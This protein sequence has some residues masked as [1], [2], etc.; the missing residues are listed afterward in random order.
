MGYAL[1]AALVEQLKST[2]NKGVQHYQHR[3]STT[4]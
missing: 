3:I 1:G 2:E 4:S